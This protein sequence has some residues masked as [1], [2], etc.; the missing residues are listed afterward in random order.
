MKRNERVEVICK[1]VLAEF[2]DIDS[3]KLH[4]AVN[5]GVRESGR[6]AYENH[7]ERKCQWETCGKYVYAKKRR[8]RSRKD[9]VN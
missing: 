3:L 9:D 8:K 4:H 5:R 1:E 7:M 2:P 6:I